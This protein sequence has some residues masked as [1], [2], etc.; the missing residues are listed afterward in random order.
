MPRR[1]PLPAPCELVVETLSH[2]GRGI[3]RPHGKTTFIDG[4]LPGETVQVQYTST[5]GKFDEAR[6][7]AV[8]LPSPERVTPPCAHADRCGGC[9]LQHLGSDAQLALKQRMLAEQ[10]QHFGGLVPARWLPPLRG[11]VTGYRSKARLGVK[12]VEAR[13]QVLVGFREKRNH[14][15]AALDQ[16]AVLVP[17][18][19][20][21]LADLAALIGSLAAK[22]RIPQIE[23]A[24]GDDEV[25]LVFRHL[26]PL[27]DADQQALLAFC[28]GRGWH[29]YLDRKST[30]LNSSHR[31]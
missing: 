29:C 3:A 17:P 31:I 21:A 28:Q 1:K 25:A 7:L 6:T 12:Y 26:D 15:I 10:L 20:E 30:R 5:R 27:S 16:C 22:R 9:S 2:D 14:F 11:P 19:G 4:A 23:V 13:E 8:T 18:L 24:A